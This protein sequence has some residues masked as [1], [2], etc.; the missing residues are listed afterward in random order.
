MKLKNKIIT[1]VLTCVLVPFLLCG[2]VIFRVV[3]ASGQ[4][5]FRDY[6]ENTTYLFAQTVQLYFDYQTA[7]IT[8][9][10][11]GS[12]AA[13]VFDGSAENGHRRDVLANMQNILRRKV[14]A[15]SS[16]EAIYLVSADGTVFCSSLL[17]TDADHLPVPLPAD[18]HTKSMPIVTGQ[19]LDTLYF[20]GNNFYSIIMPVHK[21]DGTYAGCIVQQYSLAFF[22]NLAG[23]LHLFSGSYVF[24]LDQNGGFIVN[25]KSIVPN[26]D[27]LNARI[28]TN[29]TKQIYEIDFKSRPTGFINYSIGN[30][31]KCGYYKYLSSNGWTVFSSVPVS[32]MVM[33][34]LLPDK[35]LLA[36]CVLILVFGA[37]MARRTVRQAAASNKRFRDVITAIQN[38]DLS[39]RADISDDEDYA[40]YRTAFNHLIDYMETRIEELERRSVKLAQS[41]ERYRIITDYTKEIIFEWDFETDETEYSFTW[42]KKFGYDP[43]MKNVSKEWPECDYIHQDDMTVFKEWVAKIYQGSSNSKEEFRVKTVDD[44][45]YWIR[46]RTVPIFDQ[47]NVPVKLVGLMQDIDDSKKKENEL[48]QRADFDYLSQVYNRSAFESRVNEL[49]SKATPFSL[50]YIDIDDFRM[51]NTK[52]GHEFGDR[53]IQFIG[54]KILACVSE[55]GFAGRVGGDEFIICVT[56]PSAL[57]R[58]QQ[59]AD[60]VLSDLQ[61]GLRVRESD[62]VISVHCS[63]G[64]VYYPKHGKTFE[65]LSSCADKFMYAVKHSGKNSYLIA[66]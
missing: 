52:F 2:V 36:L 62:G 56:E 17:K 19:F 6:V 63:I 34:L 51:F 44:E 49:I 35:I 46:V 14:M 23:S 47:E 37:F 64:I 24:I 5:F 29:F 10:A 32:V 20:K 12:D 53:V 27:E 50:M 4:E 9:F 3:G 43:V 54:S 48:I 59:L 61:S 15:V 33:P 55:V 28:N 22:R 58:I 66:Q 57:M 13:A 38:G 42:W 16:L 41:N 30:E 1:I 11:A 21:R 40:Y 8:E 26:I 39:V 25:G 31:S 65:E 7:E 45:Y 60:R 18:I